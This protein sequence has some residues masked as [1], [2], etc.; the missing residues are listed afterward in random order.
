[1]FLK[2]SRR[3]LLPEFRPG[4]EMKRSDFCC[5]VLRV[6]MGPALVVR[7]ILV[8]GKGSFRKLEIDFKMIRRTNAVH[9]LIL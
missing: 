1:M 3:D 6:S 9:C 2:Y 8:H 7:A 5:G 4:E